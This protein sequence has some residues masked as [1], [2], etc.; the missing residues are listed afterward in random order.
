MI[1]SEKDKH[2][3]DKSKK[4]PEPQKKTGFYTAL[5]GGVGLM[6]TLA[7]VIGYKTFAPEA[8]TPNPNPGLSDT[9]DIGGQDSQAVGRSNETPGNFGY[10]TPEDRGEQSDIGEPLLEATPDDTAKAVPKESPEPAVV[11]P[12]PA[13][14]TQSP[15]PAASMTE[16]ETQTVDSTAV[17]QESGEE[18]TAPGE[19]KEI[20]YMYGVNGTEDSAEA[21]G[22]TAP[23]SFTVFEEGDAMAWPLTGEIVMAYSMDH[24]IYDKTLDQY[25]T[26]SS[27]SIAS[28]EGAEVR[29][30]AD[31]LVTAV[32]KSRENGRTVVLEHGNGWQTTYCQLQDDVPVDVGSVVKQGQ[33]LGNVSAPSMYSVLLGPHLDFSVARSGVVMNPLDMLA[34]ME[35]E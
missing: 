35:T 30:A 3:T 33:V 15:P 11:V 5:Y 25:R 29:A 28:E 8:M 14:A 2:A 12:T 32:E 24:V 21:S 1:E 19:Q 20:E 7:V 10:L 4:K 18:A 31:G 17:V 27:I 16:P 34:K 6:L 9:A 13:P 26:N 23:P 22:I